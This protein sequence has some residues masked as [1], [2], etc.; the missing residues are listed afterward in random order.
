MTPV[1]LPHTA[2]DV[3]DQLGAPAMSA[4]ERNEHQRMQALRDEA[5]ALG[6]SVFLLLWPPM[7]WVLLAVE[8]PPDAGISDPAELIP[9]LMANTDALEQMHSHAQ[10]GKHLVLLSMGNAGPV[11]H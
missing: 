10:Q 2:L 7:H 3:I 4:T 8:T 11:L 6:G 1:F 9:S 5:I